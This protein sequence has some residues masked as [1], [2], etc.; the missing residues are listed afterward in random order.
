LWAIGYNNSIV[1]SGPETQ[2]PNP[3]RLWKLDTIT[4]YDYY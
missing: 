3:H 4:K 2:F 1:K